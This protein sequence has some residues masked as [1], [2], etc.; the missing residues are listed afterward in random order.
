[1]DA[2]N[3]SGIKSNIVTS[4]KPSTEFISPVRWKSLAH[5]VFLRVA[6]ISEACEVVLM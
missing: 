6:D 4:V 3:S 1:M 5:P 2:S